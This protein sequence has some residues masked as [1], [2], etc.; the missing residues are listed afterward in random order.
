MSL[1]ESDI[2]DVLQ[3]LR[4]FGQEHV[5][6]TAIHKHCLERCLHAGD[7]LPQSYIDRL[8]LSFLFYCSK[9]VDHSRT[10]QNLADFFACLNSAR[11]ELSRIS[12]TACV[13]LIWQF[14]DRQYQSKRWSEAADWFLA[15]THQTFGSI[16]ALS[17]SK[18]LRKAALCHIQ[19]SDYAKAAA[20]IRRCSS[21]EAATHYV[22]L[23]TAVHQGTS[24][25][26]L[27]KVP[28]YKPI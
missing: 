3:E 28:L 1:T 10:M 13:T 20:V 27:Q 11:F 17:N 12:A 19:Q 25:F 8:L 9:D 23:L 14:G 2:T 22:R 21:D 24:R 4:S 16:A 6:V 18:C 26:S 7:Q 5:L 15:A